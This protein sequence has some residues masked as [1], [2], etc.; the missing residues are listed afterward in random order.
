MKWSK[1]KIVSEILTLYKAES[2]L[3]DGYVNKNYNS[4]YNAARRQFGS[5]KN[6]IEAAG[7]NYD[8]IKL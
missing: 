8:K 7:L 1:G 6:A 3:N 2:R 5:W 4:L